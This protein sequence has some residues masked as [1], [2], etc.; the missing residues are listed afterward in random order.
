[1]NKK[2]FLLTFFSLL[3]SAN[4]FAL[5]SCPTINRNLYLGNSGQD[6]RQLQTYLYSYYNYTSNPTGYFG[7]ITRRLVQNFQRQF[8]ILPVGSVGPITRQA[9]LNNCQNIITPPNADGT[10][11]TNCQVWYDGCNTCSRQYS[12]GPLACSLLACFAHNTPY[13]K[14]YFTNPGPY[15]G[16]ICT[17]DAKLCPN[18]QYVGRTGPNCQFVCP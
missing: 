13:C 14:Q 16:V 6:V 7:L 11:P 10:A 1:M 12:G 17:Q 9:I 3:L 4:V 5:P 8:K 18:G 15:E 2:I